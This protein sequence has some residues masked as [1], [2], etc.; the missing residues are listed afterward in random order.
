MTAR[1]AA[2]GESIFL[3]VG[4]THHSTGWKVQLQQKYKNIKTEIA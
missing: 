2:K 1:I 4:V 3:N